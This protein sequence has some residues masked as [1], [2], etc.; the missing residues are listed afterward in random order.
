MVR[1]PQSSRSMNFWLGLRFRSLF[2]RCYGVKQHFIRLSEKVH[3]PR[4]TLKQSD[5][6]WLLRFF[7]VSHSSRIRSSFSSS[8]LRQKSQRRQPFSVLSEPIRDAIVWHSST[9]FS[10]RTFIR[11]MTRIMPIVLANG[12]PKPEK[13][14][15][16][17]SYINNEGLDEWESSIEKTETFWSTSTFG[18]TSID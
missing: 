16:F 14:K 13:S 9:R 3:R 4:S 7:R 6:R 10:A 11:M 17:G 18:G 2:F 8:I 12:L 1:P 15:C 5:F